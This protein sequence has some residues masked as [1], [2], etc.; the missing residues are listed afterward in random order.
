MNPALLTAAGDNRAIPLLALDLIRA[1]TT[2]GHDYCGNH[3]LNNLSFGVTITA[4]L[5]CDQSAVHEPE[6]GRTARAAPYFVGR[7]FVST[8][9]RFWVSPEVQPQGSLKSACS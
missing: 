5:G 2:R 3:N 8:Y 7:F 4:T 9:G 1:S 6:W